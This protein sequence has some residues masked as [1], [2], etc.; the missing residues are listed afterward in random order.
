MIGANDAN[1]DWL[2]RSSSSVAHVEWQVPKN[3][4][5]THFSE[6]DRSNNLTRIQAYTSYTVKC[7]F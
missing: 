3:T 1:K 2:A 7:C 6:W 5:A 4:T